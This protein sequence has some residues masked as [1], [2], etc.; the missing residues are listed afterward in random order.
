MIGILLQ[1]GYEATDRLE[2]ADFIVINTCGFLEASR[3]ESI[4]TI[5]KAIQDR[6]PQAKVIAT[7]CM[8]QSHKEVVESCCPGVHY[9]LGSGDVEGILK[10][11]TQEERGELVS[12]NKSYLEV[13]EVPRTV[14]T[15]KQYAYLKIAEGCRK[16]C[17]YCIIPDIKGPLKSKPVDKV[18][19]EIKALIKNGFQE[20]IL[21][22]QDLGDWGRDMGFQGSQGLLHLLTAITE[23]TTIA[24]SPV[25]FR[26]LYV[27]PDE[28][29][30]ELIQCIKANSK[31]IIP[32]LDMP[33]QHA[34]SDI[35]KAMR[36]N[37][38]KEEVIQC[39]TQLRKAIPD[40]TIRTSLIVGFPGETEE[41]FEEL[42]DF[43]NEMKLDNVGIFTYSKEEKSH[44]A[45][46]PNHIPEEVKEKR[47]RR[48]M[49]L[50]KKIATNLNKKRYLKKIIEVTVDGYHPET[51]LLMIGR[52]QGQCP[53]IDGIVLI[54]DG[55]LVTG[56]GKRY[57]V[58]ITDISEYDLVGRVIKEI[59]E[60]SETPSREAAPS[61]KH[62]S[63]SHQQ[64]NSR[65]RVV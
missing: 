50:Q 60:M 2:L 62:D 14:S 56:F 41:H 25:R 17:S 26:L 49:S 19:S 1:N 28:I 38:T 42:C 6:K 21:I 32:Y 4:D 10:A 37:T 24:Q 12:D 3:Q 59:V 53:D 16:R 31:K 47:Y 36:R 13:G 55:R 57:L 45:L 20:I 40:I 58:E 39:I 33:I 61:K 8:V 27:Y 54:N 15:P 64:S 9:L 5:N 18:L 48:L 52:H 30:P 63:H 35:L 22:A 29:T 43:V 11:V 34:N 51:K 46:L 44:S 23:D 65:L 7:G